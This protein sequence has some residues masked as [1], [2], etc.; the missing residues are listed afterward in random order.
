MMPVRGAVTPISGNER[1]AAGPPNV[2]HSV[3]PLT[4]HLLRFNNEEGI[5]MTVQI[6]FINGAWCQIP[7]SMHF[8]SS[9]RQLPK[10]VQDQINQFVKV[11]DAVK[12][13]LNTS[14]STKNPTLSADEIPIGLRGA[15]QPSVQGKAV[16][17]T[18]A[19]NT[20]EIPMGLK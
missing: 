7:N 9:L 13:A 8:V 16:A 17:R 6:V 4:V 12:Q 2:V 18:T 5:A 11:P 15:E 3:S 19:L 20:D 1:E 10:R 14:G